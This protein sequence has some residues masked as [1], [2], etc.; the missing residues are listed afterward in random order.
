LIL[1]AIKL[2]KKYNS[3]L[4]NKK[5]ENSTMA[6]KITNAFEEKANKTRNVNKNTLVSVFVSI[7]DAPIL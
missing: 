7:I 4:L 5:R 1:G 6:K 2:H 3:F